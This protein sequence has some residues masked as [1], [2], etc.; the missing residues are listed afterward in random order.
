MEIRIA[1]GKAAAG[2]R[3]SG[4][5]HHG[6]PISPR[7]RRAD[8]SR[9]LEELAVIIERPLAAP[10]PLDQIPPLL[11]VLV[12]AVMIVLA[13]AEHIEFVLI[14]S[15]NDIQSEAPATQM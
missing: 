4:V 10:Y 9:Q 2:R 7:R 6:P 8:H 12:A 1:R 5:H 3:R 11:P 13:D 15:A 14:P